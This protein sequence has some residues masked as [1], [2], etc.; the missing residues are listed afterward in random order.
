MACGMCRYAVQ[1]V[2]MFYIE[3]VVDSLWNVSVC[4]AVCRYVLHRGCCGWLMQCVGCSSSSPMC[5]TLHELLE[6]EISR[7]AHGV[8]YTLEKKTSNPHIA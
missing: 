1:F 5:S 3:G 8:Y 6:E 2:G 4:S 7:A